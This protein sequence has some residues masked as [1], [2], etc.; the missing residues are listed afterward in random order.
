[1]RLPLPQRRALSAAL[2]LEEVEGAAPEERTI[3]FAVFRLLAER[4]GGPLL[5]AVDDVQW[6]DAASA[7]VLAF[8]F[9]RL[10]AAPVAILVARRS[11]G[12][13]AAPL[14]LDRA[15]PSERLRR[16]RLGPLSVGATHRL[17]RERL[18][19]SFPR[20][21][22]L[23]LHDTSGGNPF[24][25]LELGRALEQSG[26]RADAGERLTVPTSLTELVSTRLAALPVEV[27]EVLEPVALL[28]EPTVSIVEAVASDGATV[29]GRLRAA[30]AA[31]IVELNE[32]RVRFSH[33]LLAARVE[34]EL[35]P[36]R[37]RSL[38]RGLAELVGDAGAARPASCSRRRRGRRRGRRR[39]GDR[40][41]DCGLAWRIRSSGG[42]GRALG[43][44]HARRR[45]GLGQAPAAASRRRPSL[46]E[47]RRGAI[48]GDPRAAPRAATAWCRP[49]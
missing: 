14:G 6:L 37:R 47:R 4:G 2:L 31:A 33:P 41:R 18:G 29:R 13:E 25:A 38:H 46:R 23:K 48:A 19:V 16:L 12:S 5:V 45:C 10:A 9:R 21:T 20:P 40:F 27:R 39:T 28:S 32:E 8:A 34:A 36:R 11:D 42:A 7:S 17:L 22:L 49:C 44:A 30:E 26:G 1:M 35:D 3:A 43:L 15:F 24:Y